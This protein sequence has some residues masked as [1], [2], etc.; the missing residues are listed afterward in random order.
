MSVKLYT[1]W[2]CRFVRGR[3]RFTAER[4]GDLVCWSHSILSPLS[5]NGTV[6]RHRR[7]STEEVPIN[8]STTQRVPESSGKQWMSTACLICACP[9][10]T[11][12]VNKI[13]SEHGRG[14]C[15]KGRMSAFA[16]DPTGREKDRSSGR[17]RSKTPVAFRKENI[18][19]T[20]AQQ[21]AVLEA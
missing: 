6:S 15:E 11:H 19:H 18:T 5:L 1:I 16:P 12:L 2:G 3:H 14:E 4:Y 21:P 17:A 20:W 8:Q 7:S 10:S 9:C 13:N